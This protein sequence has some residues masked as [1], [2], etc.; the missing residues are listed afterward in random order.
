M[1]GFCESWA[2]FIIVESPREMDS[3]RHVILVLSGKGGVGKS[4]VSFNL[5]LALSLNGYRVGLL[6]VDLCGPSI[7]RICGLD[8]MPVHQGSQGWIPVREKPVSQRFVIAVGLPLV[9]AS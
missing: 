3:V 5:A 8:G 4:T 1:A 6:D 9:V 7:P 2:S